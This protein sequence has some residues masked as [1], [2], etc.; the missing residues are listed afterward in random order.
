MF[1]CMPVGG[2]WP[3]IVPGPIWLLEETT[4]EASAVPPPRTTNARIVTITFA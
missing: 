1:A 4:Y 2:L 3:E